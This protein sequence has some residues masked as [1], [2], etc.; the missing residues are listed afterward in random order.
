MSNTQS[1]RRRIKSITNTRQITKAMELVAAAKMRKAQERAQNSRLYS[2]SAKESL[3]LL[4]IAAQKIT[5]PLLASKKSAAGASRKDLLIVITSD[6]GLAGS[7]N[8]FCLRLASSFLQTKIDSVDI[9]TIGK[10]ARD[11]FSR[12]DAN[13]AAT[14]IDLPP[15]PS[16]NDLRPVAEIA[17][18]DFLRRQYSQVNIVYTKFHSTV[19]QE[20]VLE[21]FLPIENKDYTE[22]EEP[23]PEFTFEP[24]EKNVLD[25]VV[26]RLVETLLYQ[27]LLESVASEHSA[28]MVAMKN[29]SDNASD[30]IK[31]LQLTYNGVR[32]AGITQELAEITAGSNA[33]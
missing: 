19:K 7:Y 10:K 3:S 14:F 8:S 9:L 2:S 31:D 32:Q 20:A 24:N 4:S 30:I 25:Y 15:Y 27:K 6:R 16:F 18:D 33:I 5:H 22:G 28:R 21:Q 12:T 29:A 17:I 26:P 1:I 11:F 23:L 13:I